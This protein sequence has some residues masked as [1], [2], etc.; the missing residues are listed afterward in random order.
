MDRQT[1]S[2]K[3]TLRQRPR[4]RSKRSGTVLVLVLVVIV[5]LALAAANYSK[6]MTTELDAVASAERDA[7]ARA[8]IDSGVD[9]V[10]A[11]LQYRAALG[12]ENLQHN[13]S[14]FQ[15]V[16]VA[17]NDRPRLRGRF[18]VLT[19]LEQDPESRRVRY[20]LIDESARLNINLVEKLGLDEAAARTTLMGLPGMT[21][22]IADAILDF[23]DADDNLREYGAEV[24]TYESKSPPYAAKNGPLES[25][26]ELL[27]VDGVTADLLYGEDANRNGLLDPNENDGD[28]SPPLDNGDGI[29]Q[30]GWSA[31]LTV[32]SRESNLR[33]DGRSRIDLNNGLLTDLYDQLEEEFSEDVAKFVIGFRI[34]GPKD[35]RPTDDT[36]TGTSGSKSVA[37]S[38]SSGQQQQQQQQFVNGIATAIA[39]AAFSSGGQV[40]RGGIDISQ[41]G[42]NRVNSLWDLIGSRCDVMI[43]G[44]KTTLSSPWPAEPGQLEAVLPQLIDSLSTTADLYL[45]GRVNINQARREVIIGLPD[46]TEELV[47]AILAGQQIDSDGTPMLDIIQKRSTTGWLFTEGLIEDIWVMRSLDPYLTARGDVYRAQV[48]GYF[49]GGGPVARAEAMIDATQKPPRVTFYRDLTDLGRGYS[50]AQ[51]Q[52]AGQ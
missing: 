51:F 41:G 16:I 24:E 3:R 45:E 1:T 32:H 22:A 10:A 14:Q 52:G 42:P 18:T 23:V 44:T 2:G 37:S 6:L 49:D 30:H 25:L 48:V 17:A 46:M 36:G 39:G 29:L 5:L 47:D 19:A 13:P 9:Y 8:L 7:Q 33:A 43:N 31:F 4:P 35:Q 50:R 26:D 12:E 11:Q 21:E 38:T 28:A 34:S 40:T 20:G 27:L 15:G